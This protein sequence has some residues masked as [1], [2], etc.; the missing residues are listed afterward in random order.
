[1]DARPMHSRE[2]YGGGSINP[3]SSFTCLWNTVFGSSVYCTS[4][5]MSGD[6]C[7]CRVDRNQ[8]KICSCEPKE[9]CPV[10]Y[11]L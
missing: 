7:N 6:M 4:A 5:W 8:K 9:K 1:M 11:A 2:D 10:S 3:T